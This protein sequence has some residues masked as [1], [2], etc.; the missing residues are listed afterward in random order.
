MKKNIKTGMLVFL[1]VIPVFVFMFLKFF[2][3]NYYSLPVYFATDSTYQDGRYKITDA[4]TIPDFKLTNQD[5]NQFSSEA[6]KGKITIVDFFFT[7]CGGIC[8]KMTRHLGRVQDAFKNDSNVRI[9]SFTV[10]PVFDGVDVLKKY[11]AEFGADNNKWIFLTGTKDSIYQIAQKGFF[12]SAMEDE[13]NPVDFIHSEKLV[14]VDKVGRIRGYY[15]GTDPED[16]NR[17]IAEI[18]VLNYEYGQD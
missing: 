15:N 13:A 14:L 1:L 10:D 2:G 12:L 17:L 6:L 18:K 8:P 7:R 5:G 16:V 3:K 9:V 11:S 4:H